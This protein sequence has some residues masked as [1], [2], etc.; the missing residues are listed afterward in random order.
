[1]SHRCE[2]FH[3]ARYTAFIALYPV[4]IL[5]GEMPLYYAGLPYLRERRLHSVLLPNALNFG[6]DYHLAC[7]VWARPYPN[8]YPKPNSL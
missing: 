4:G 7:Q 1:M 6:F 2:H 5:L 3:V 8:P